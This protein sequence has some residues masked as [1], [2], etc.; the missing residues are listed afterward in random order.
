MA[1]KGNQNAVKLRDPE[2]RQEAY[3]QYCDHLSKGKS[4]KSWV[5]EHPSLRCTSELI[6]KI[7]KNEEEFDPLTKQ[8]A[9][10]KGYAYWEQKVIEHVLGLGDN[11]T[12]TAALNMWM[13]NRFGWDKPESSFSSQTQNSIDSLVLAIQKRRQE[14]KS[15]EE[16]KK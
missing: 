5:F 15:E 10:A 11:K 9:E 16:H 14:K 12:N 1:P 8:I 6:E 13:R 3:N 2:I 4:K 7:I